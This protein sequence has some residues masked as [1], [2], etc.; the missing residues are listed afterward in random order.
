MKTPIPIAAF[1]L[2]AIGGM[3]AASAVPFPQDFHGLR[4]LGSSDNETS[5]STRAAPVVAKLGPY[6]SDAVVLVTWEGALNFAKAPHGLTHADIELKRDGAALKA[7]HPAATFAGP[8]SFRLSGAE[9]LFLSRGQQTTLS[10]EAAG[11]EAAAPT[12]HARLAV[13]AIATTE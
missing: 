4:V 3:A 5:G 1:G 13:T 10:M 9:K 12:A 11:D 7:E 2:V 8:G 6:A